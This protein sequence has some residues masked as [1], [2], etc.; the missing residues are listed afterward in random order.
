MFGPKSLVSLTDA[1]QLDS[2]ICDAAGAITSPTA[3]DHL[4]DRL[5]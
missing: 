4:T 3:C 5:T 1:L 2:L